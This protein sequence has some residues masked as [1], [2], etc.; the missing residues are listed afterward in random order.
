VNSTD[1]KLPDSGASARELAERQRRLSHLSLVLY[2]DPVLRSVCQPV[3]TFDS[4]LR[5]FVR[6][7]FELM[8]THGGI[9]LAGP[10]VALEQRL[11][12]A[13]IEEK[14]LCLT[15]PE[16]QDASEPGEFIEGCLSLPDVRVKVPRP[17]RI[18]VTGHDQYGRKIRFGATG[19]WARVIQHE[20]DHLNGVLI[21]D[22]GRPLGE[23]CLQ[24]PLR[25]PAVLVEERKRQ[26]RLF[27]RHA[28]SPAHKR[29]A[30]PRDDA[31]TDIL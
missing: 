24:C 26:S 13:A 27:S 8:Q 16:I 19:L 29:R 1:D 11:L 14:H 25:L 7:M 20:L 23:E 3:E 17:E 28:S 22:R 10:Q 31:Q 18:R 30:K 4:T 2:P 5:D 15:N 9:G 21:C 12:I 6:E